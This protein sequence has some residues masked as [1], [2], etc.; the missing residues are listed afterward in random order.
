[1]HPQPV[2]FISFKIINS[3]QIL[4]VHKGFTC[5][6]FHLS[7]FHPGYGLFTVFTVYYVGNDKFCISTFHIKYYRFKCGIIGIVP[8]CFVEKIWSFRRIIYVEWNLVVSYVFNLYIQHYI[9]TAVK[10]LFF[11]MEIYA[12]DISLPA[13]RTGWKQNNSAE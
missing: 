6:E 5:R 11:K 7:L 4:S 8:S 9:F 12:E 2:V 13:V 1:M 3:L 10:F